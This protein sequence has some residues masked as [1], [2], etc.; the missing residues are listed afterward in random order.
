MKLF[1]VIS[2]RRCRVY[3]SSL[4]NVM[5]WRPANLQH[6]QSQSI[7]NNAVKQQNKTRKYSVNTQHFYWSN[8]LHV[9]ALYPGHLQAIPQPMGGKLL[10]NAK[11]SQKN[12]S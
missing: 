7:M 2:D 10:T 3:S 1:R 5:P 4:G 12:S 6:K 9:S 8:W 11:Y